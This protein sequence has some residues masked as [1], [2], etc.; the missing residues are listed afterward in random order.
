MGSRFSKYIQAN[1]EPPAYGRRSELIGRNLA[2]ADSGE[3][4]C[5][6]PRRRAAGRR[7]D[8]SWRALGAACLARAYG[9]V[10]RY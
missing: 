8:A 10:L 2:L 7:R 6:R 9:Y 3:P 1:V 4:C 5:C